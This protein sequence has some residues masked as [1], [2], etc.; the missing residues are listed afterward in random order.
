MAR[1]FRVLEPAIVRDLTA[2]L[3]RMGA[4]NLS[5]P[6]N[7]LKPEVKAIIVFDRKDRRY[8][9]ECSKYAH[10]LD[11]LRAA[12]LA[13]DYLWKALESYGVSSASKTLD[14]MFEQVFGGFEPTPDSSVLKLTSGDWWDILGVARDASADDIKVAWRALARRLHPD[15]GGDAEQFKRL[16]DAYQQAMKARGISDATL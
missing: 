6:V 4:T 10:R 15:V 14:R 16:N 12:S 5:I 3:K 13:I 7:L 2:T 11:N 9:F 8:V 1:Y